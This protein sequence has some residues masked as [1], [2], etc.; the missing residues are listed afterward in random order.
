MNCAHC[1][2]DTFSESKPIDLK[3]LEQPLL[4]LYEMGVFHYVLQ[5]GEPLEDPERLESIISMIYPDETYVTLVSN[6]W[7]MT[8][9][10]IQ[11]LKKMQVDKIAFSLDSGIEDEHDKNRKKG[12]YNRIIDAI[13][14]VLK[15]GL[16][17]SIS[18]VVSHDSLHSIGFKKCYEFARDKSIR[19]D[20]Q[21][22]MPVGKWDGK[23]DCLI[24]EKDAEYIKN[25]QRN[26]PILSDGKS[27]VKR[28]IFIGEKDYCHAG[29]EF[30][31]ISSD[32]QLLPCNFLQFSL[33]KIND[34]SI[35]RMRNDLLKSRWFKGDHP[36]CLCGEDKEF[37][38]SYILPYTIS[39]KPLDAHE[40]F[41]LKREG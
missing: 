7:N 25:L 9:D 21:I 4:E 22:A 18:T 29:T 24:T 19:L 23:T 28:D 41:N 10:N 27:M 31:A 35:E 36:V 2:A 6:G 33:G 20:I 14:Q 15:E 11:W 1:Y 39:K 32:G 16:L 37:I 5:G 3:D 38:N 26:S 17:V 40:C 12:S 30:L 13:D 34:N 8:K